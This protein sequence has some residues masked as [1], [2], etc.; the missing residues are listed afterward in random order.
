MM[1]A[2][3]IKDFKIFPEIN[4]WAPGNNL[5]VFYG[6]DGNIYLVLLRYDPNTNKIYPPV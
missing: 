6:K 5:G 4:N 2:G 3:Q 1:N